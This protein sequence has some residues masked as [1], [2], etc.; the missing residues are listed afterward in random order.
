QQQILEGGDLCRGERRP[1]LVELGG[2]LRGREHGEV[3]AHRA[4]DRAGAMRQPLRL[5]QGEQRVARGRGEHGGDGQA[6]AVHAQGDVDA[7]AAGLGAVGADAVHPAG[8]EGAAQI[9]RAV[10]GR[11]RGEGDDHAVITSTPASASSAP[12]SAGGGASVTSASTSPRAAKETRWVA[13]NFEESASI[14]RRRADCAIAAFTAAS[15]WSGVV[16]PS[17]PR[18]LQPRKTTSGCS[19]RIASTVEAPTAASV[20]GRTRPGS[21]WTARS[22][23]ARAP[24]AI[25]GALVMTGPRRPARWGSSSAVEEP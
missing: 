9:D 19:W 5:Q 23:W 6:G 17:D 8:G 25:A 2:D 22:V 24:W 13:P 1:R 7:L 12:S 10:Q 21:T 11:V 18:P 3:G 15:S 14:T 16:K 4:R 20:V